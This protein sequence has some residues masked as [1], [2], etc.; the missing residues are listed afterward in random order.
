MLPSSNNSNNT[1]NNNNNHQSRL[2]LEIEKSKKSALAETGVLGSHSRTSI[3]G[4][5][6]WPNDKQLGW[7][8]KN[9]HHHQFKNPIRSSGCSA[10]TTAAAGISYNKWND[11]NNNSNLEDEHKASSDVTSSWLNSTGA[12]IATEHQYGD[13]SNNNNGGITWHSTE[14]GPLIYSP[15][16]KMVSFIAYYTR[17]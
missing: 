16:V 17:K 14:K 11:T 3:G 2:S 4:T 1:I 5:K 12:G 15:L 7:Q 13:I 9:V 8:P 10:T 6:A